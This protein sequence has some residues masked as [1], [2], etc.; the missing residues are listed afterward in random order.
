MGYYFRLQFRML[1]RQIAGFGLPPFIGYLLAVPA[2]IGL[3][4]LLFQKIEFAEY[5]CF[6]AAVG[7]IAGLG[8]SGRNDFLKNTFS[9]KDYF[10]IRIVEN[11]LVAL[12]FVVFL[13]LWGDML[14][15]VL[16]ILA[17][18][19]LVFFKVNVSQ[20]IKIPTPFY[21]YPFE[22]IIGFRSY[23]AFL[24]LIWILSVAAIIAGN[25]NLGIFS[26]ALVFLICFMF[27][28]TPEN[29]FFVWIF[30]KS[31][32]QFLIFK[33]RIALLYSALI[34]LPV[35]ILLILFYPAFALVTCGVVL[36]GFIYLITVVLAKY[37]AF[38]DPINVPQSIFLAFSV[39]FP[40]MLLV[41]IPV[42][43]KQS[44]KQL[45]NYLNDTN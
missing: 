6:I 41:A 38:P 14:F 21:R 15:S 18:V 42:F 39:V 31:P 19:L 25:F 43:Y 26:L 22:F 7:L 30:S 9:A 33:I 3:S 36:L 32:R 8:N 23:F 37:S 35:A 5:I 2:F 13:A 20:E 27:Y 28:S 17:A 45:N 16:L 44:I 34:S 4:V 24:I 40:P 12:P 1:T 29:E 11:L 10:R